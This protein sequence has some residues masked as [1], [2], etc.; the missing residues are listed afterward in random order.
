[1]PSDTEILTDEA[2]RLNRTI[3]PV[4]AGFIIDMVDFATFGPIGLVLGLPVGGLAGYW[5]GNTLGL[6]KQSCL[7]CALAAGIYCTIPGTELL[8]LGTMVGAYARY[9]Q[10]EK[11]QVALPS[12]P[13][14]D[15]VTEIE[16]Q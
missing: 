14:A 13:T 4:M 9:Q 6:S 8:P 16:K 7:Y 12:P 3:G 1:M 5:M 11:E 15:N 2:K 10:G